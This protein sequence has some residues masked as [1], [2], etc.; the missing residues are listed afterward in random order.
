MISRT[1]ANVNTLTRAYVKKR[2]CVII[3]VEFRI[4]HSFF[5]VNNNP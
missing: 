5:K 3:L 4:I 2:A 1:V